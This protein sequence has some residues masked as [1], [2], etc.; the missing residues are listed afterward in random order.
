MAGKTTL[1]ELLMVAYGYQDRSRISGP[2]W[3]DTASY[4]LTAT[5]PA[6]TTQ[7]DFQVMLQNLLKDRFKLQARQMVAPSPIYELRIAKGGSKVGQGVKAELT[8]NDSEVGQPGANGF[9]KLSSK[10]G[11]ATVDGV[12]GRR[13]ISARQMPI[14]SLE[15]M[16]RGDAGRPITDKTGLTGVFDF[17]LEFDTRRPGTKASPDIGPSL[18]QAVEEQLGLELVASTVEVEKLVVDSAVRVTVGK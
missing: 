9:P 3:M 13:R 17:T 10:R 2:A 14:R 16:L 6:T 5:M 12:G 7:A 15:S 1:A 4:D 11:G 18:A 8:D